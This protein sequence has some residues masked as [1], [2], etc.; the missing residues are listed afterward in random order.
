MNEEETNEKK[1]KLAKIRYGFTWAGAS[2]NALATSMSA[3]YTIY[4]LA[5]GKYANALLFSGTTLIFGFL[6]Y[7]N[8]KIIPIDKR[9]ISSL[10]KIVAGEGSRLDGNKTNLEE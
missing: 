7:M 5:E 8:Y 2:L 4:E 3:G 9:E 6:A 10:E 1:L